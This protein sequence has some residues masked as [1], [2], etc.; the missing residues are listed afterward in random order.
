VGLSPGDLI[1]V[2]YLKEGLERQ[3]FRI[4]RMQPGTNFQTL[5]VTAQW[6]DDAWY[7]ATGALGTGTRRQPGAGV[8]IPRPL[9][10][11]TLDSHGMEQFGITETTTE[12]T[13]GSFT[14]TLSIAFTPPGMVTASAVGIPLVSLNAGINSTGG[15]IAGGQTLYY[16]VSALDGNGAETALSFI[17]PAT[18]PATTNTN[19]VTLQG[20]SFSSSTASFNVYRGSNPL[21]LLRIAAAV[22]VASS[23]TDSGA[24]ASLI[25][26]PDENYDHANVYWRLEL[27]PEASAGLFSATTIGNV[28]LGM[29][30]NEFVGAVA[31]VT[32]GT[33]E[34][35]E[36]AIIA[37]TATTI[38]VSPK[39][40]VTPD[41]T[42]FFV[43][44]NATWN[45]GGL[46]A[47]S[48]VSVEVPNRAGQTV[49]IS[50]RSANA[51]NQE[52]S[53]DLNPLT[54]WDV[55]GAAGGGVDADVPAQPTFGL[56]LVGGGSVE[57]AGIG[58]SDLTNTH[59]IS[60]GTLTLFYWNEL[61][62]PTVFTLAS[63]I[64][65][66][67]TTITLS[68]AG[69]A[70]AGS[71]IQIESEAMTV[72]A[73]AGGGTSYTVTRGTEGSTAAAHAAGVLIY[74]L[75]EDVTIVPFIDDF[76]G[77]PASGVYSTSV[78]LPDVRIAAAEFFLTSVRGNSAAG[79]ASFA[80]TTDQGLR[81][82]SGGQ[83]SIQVEGYLAIQTNAAPPL[84]MEAA[85][86]ARDIFAVLG[87]AP[88]PAPGSSP[89]TNTLQLQLRVG[90]TVYA[91]LSFND[92]ATTSNTVNGFGLAALASG[93]VLSLD[94]L[95][96]NSA[97]N[98]LPGR[99][100]TVV[101]R[102]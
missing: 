30:A 52:S 87:E 26:P 28:G 16:A 67:D 49:E 4:V 97:A 83:L 80:A 89:G 79:I 41:S 74:H 78:F 22:P 71:R 13:D 2:T 15:T 36:R 82:L 96:V 9:V 17:V 39:W 50:G 77:S 92:G 33:G 6:H 18:I 95:S 43:V 65:A 11:S 31:R 47:T 58:F 98:S 68:V 63:A 54:R 73:T 24:T 23:Y 101:V 81:T 75:N 69:P 59:T 20:L 99:D 93:A 62:S 37:N 61:N 85:H 60:A 86:A 3:P 46:S 34:A 84:V 102:L 55:G 88:A 7:T 42:S 70:T 45:F 12:S 48:P 66:A 57:L 53:T 27:Q 8:G 14:V 56:D 29:T 5:K 76:F 21:E 94:I 19:Q 72:T 44:A 91:T 10:G 32:R 25:G 64:A 38:T 100:L 90:S 51:L 35:Q 1:T 40:T